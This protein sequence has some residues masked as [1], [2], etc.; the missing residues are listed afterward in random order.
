MKIQD[1]IG[2][3]F[4]RKHSSDM[5]IVRTS[6]GSRYNQNLVPNLTDKTADV[7]GGDG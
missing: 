1:F 4:N 7:P 2:F 3:S 6:D 5:K